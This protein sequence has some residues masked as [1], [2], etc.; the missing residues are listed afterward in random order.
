LS[1]VK[2]G[3]GSTNGRFKSEQ[4]QNAGSY[5]MAQAAFHALNLA[6]Q[7]RGFRVLFAA[8]LAGRI[9]ATAVRR[10]A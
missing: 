1:G 7:R 6:E 9:R 4:G 10:P 8:L 5:S 3:G 2:L